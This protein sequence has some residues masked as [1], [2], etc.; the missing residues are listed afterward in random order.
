MI[1]KICAFLFIFIFSLTFVSSFGFGNQDGLFKSYNVNSSTTNNYYNISS[2]SFDVTD[3]QSAFDNNWTAL[4]Y[5]KVSLDTKTYQLLM[6]QL[7]Q[8]VYATLNRA[9]KG[10]E[11]GSIRRHT[12]ISELIGNKPQQQGKGGIFS[13]GKN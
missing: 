1:K 3:F 5:D 4:D 13:W 11:R 2:G 6:A 10:E 8:M 9:W 7:E 12:T